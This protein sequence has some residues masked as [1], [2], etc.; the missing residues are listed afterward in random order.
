MKI[1][2]IGGTGFIGHFAV[3][4]LQQAGHDLTVFHRGNRAIPEDLRQIVGDRNR[5]A[6]YREQFAR[7]KF[8]VVVDFVVSSARQAQRLMETLRG[9]TQRVIVLSSM[10]VYRAWGIICGLEPGALEPMPLNEDSALRTRA[11]YPPEVMKRARQ[12][13]SWLDDEYDKV[14]AERLVLNDPDLPGT[15][16]RLPMIYGP[17]D[18]AHRFYPVLKRIDDGRKQI[19]FADDVALLRTPRGYVEDVASAIVLATTER[20]AAGRV[21]NVCESE[22]FGELEWAR[23]IAAAVAWDGEFVVLPHDRTPKHLLWPANTAQ[24]FVVQSDRIRAELGYRETISRDEAFRRTIPWE[25]ANPPAPELHQ[26]D[27]AAEDAALRQ[28]RATA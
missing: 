8:D 1:L 14:P 22:C 12:M 13:V 11:P 7:E 24:Q 10:D 9:I 3:P 20:Q 26:F 4:R 28:F 19:I 15:V 17:G 6:D 18:Y 5:L 23:K 16:L 21:Y 2:V 25:R 27:Y